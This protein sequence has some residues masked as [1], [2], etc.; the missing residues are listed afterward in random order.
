MRNL[1][2]LVGL[3]AVAAVTAYPTSA[4]ACG[5]GPSIQIQQSVPEDGAENVPTNVVPWVHAFGELSLL[6]AD[7]R[8]V[9]TAV[10][11]SF[12]PLTCGPYRELIPV[13]SLAPN[14]RYIIRSSAPQGEADAGL[15][16]IS[17]VTGS[18]PLEGPPPVSP[19]VQ[20]AVV[21]GEHFMNSCDYAR[22]LGCLK[23]D[24][25]GLLDVRVLIAGEESMHTLAP[26]EHARRLL[27][28]Y[29]SGEACV[30][31]RARDSAGRF[32]E[33]RQFCV[34]T[35]GEPVAEQPSDPAYWSSLP[36]CDWT[37]INDL[38]ADVE[39]YSVP[40]FPTD[41]PIPPPDIDAGV[42]GTSSDAAVVSGSSSVDGAIVSDVAAIGDPGEADDAGGAVAS[43]DPV[44]R[45]VTDES[46]GC[47]VRAVDRTMNPLGIVVGFLTL[48]LFRA[49]RGLRART[50]GGCTVSRN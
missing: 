23:T 41:E 33:T 17:F 27:L 31:I 40:D 35:G 39:T 36:D 7:G 38:Y 19:A 1:L 45:S 21:D 48:A 44:Q 14:T 3:A 43:H 37:Q 47:S 12:G 24:Y 42:S 15:S 29:D 13:A 2:P 26:V 11:L 22:H 8:L 25:D 49:R 16:S 32:S 10:R 18:G 28:G 6:D 46:K 4:D 5:C 9:P 30:Q 50:S 20:V 34:E